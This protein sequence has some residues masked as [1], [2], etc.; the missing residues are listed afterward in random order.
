[1]RLR[2]IAI[3]AMALAVIS[4]SLISQRSLG[5]SSAARSLITAPIDE[6]KLTVLKGNT[7][8]L[9]RAQYDQGPRVSQPADGSHV[10]SN[11]VSPMTMCRK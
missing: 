11:S 2:P 7:H 10:A 4:V 8:P 1:M 3:C 6:S 5:Q 9:A